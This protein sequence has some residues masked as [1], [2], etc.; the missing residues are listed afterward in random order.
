MKSQ[1]LTTSILLAM[2]LGGIFGSIFNVFLMDITWLKIFLIDNSF[3]V[4]G[5]V[6]INLLKMLVVPLVFVSL[7]CGVAALGDVSKLGRLGGKALLFY[8]STTALAISTALILAFLVAPGKNFDFTGTTT[9][10]FVANETPSLAQTI[11]KMVPDNPINAM[12]EG[13]MLPLIIFSLLFGTA[14]VMTN[15]GGKRIE[16][17]FQDIN[18][19]NMQILH[20]VM[21]F[22][23][24]GIFCLIA[25]T[26]ANQGIEVIKPL[27][28]YFLV[29]I[30]ALLIHA[31]ITY[32]LLIKVFSNLNPWFFLKKMRPVQIFAFSTASSN[33]TIPINIENSERQL[34][35]SNSIASFTIPLGATINMDGTAIMQGVATVFI[36]NVYGIDLSLGDYLVVILTA[37]LASVGTAGVPGVGLVMLAMVLNQVGLPVEGIALII[38]VD[39]LLD[40][41]RTAVNITGDATATVIIA[42]SEGALNHKIY[43]RY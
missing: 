39:R 24:I 43:H 42:N 9:T 22:A 4:L 27:L 29:V 15:E 10:K 23:P 41:M 25:Q 18:E 30:V 26:F 31:F 14:I 35:V 32:P 36:A 2:L 40:M 28:G 12:A 11:I 3:Q 20:I 34:G 37:T 7:V 33:A 8:L 13:Q 38:G 6:F 19:I 17:F 21:K 5:Q 1:N 16:Q